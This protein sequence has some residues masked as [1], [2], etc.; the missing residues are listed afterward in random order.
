MHPDFVAIFPNW[1]PE[2]V[3]R[4]DLFRQIY[5]VKVADNIAAGGSVLV[6]LST[7]WTRYPAAVSTQAAR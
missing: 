3:A 1:Y 6:V 4:T 5:E 7:P 2:V